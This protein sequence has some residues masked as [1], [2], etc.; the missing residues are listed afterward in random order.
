MYIKTHQTA[1]KVGFVFDSDCSS[2]TDK[3]FK[4]A[5]VMKV[6][7]FLSTGIRKVNFKVTHHFF[8]RIVRAFLISLATSILK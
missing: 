5:D 4:E 3:P 8:L 6:L 7:Y 1:K 2:D